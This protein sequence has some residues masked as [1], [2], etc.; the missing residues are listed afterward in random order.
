M[1][2]VRN[3]LKQGDDLSPLLLNFALEYAI[4][5]VQVNQNGL[6]LKG[7]HQ[8]VV[9]AGDVS[10]PG[11]SVFSIKT[12]VQALLVPSK[13]NRIEEFAA[14][15]TYMGIS[16]DQDAGRIHSIKNDNISFEKW[17]SSNI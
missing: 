14:K 9:Y 5:G 10:I 12:K 7:T 4:K 6:K 13:E 11:R 1:F 17:K 16:R 2:P 3:G 15:T 8:F